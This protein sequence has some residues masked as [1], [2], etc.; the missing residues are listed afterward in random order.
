MPSMLILDPKIAVQKMRQFMFA[1][2]KLDFAVV[3]DHESW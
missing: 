3:E 2:G 1:C